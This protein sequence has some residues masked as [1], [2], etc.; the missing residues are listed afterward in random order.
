MKARLAVVAL[1]C[2]G[3]AGC[4]SGGY[5]STAPGS[6]AGEGGGAQVSASAFNGVPAAAA[7]TLTLRA[8]IGIELDGAQAF[9]PVHAPV[10]ATGPFDLAAGKGTEEIDLPEIKRQEPG[11]EHAI[12]LPTLAYLQPRG[13]RLPR[14]KRWLSAS[15]AGSES[16]NRNFP[17]FVGQVEGLNPMLLLGELAW[18]TT[19]SMPLGP[20]RQIVDHVP[21]QRYRVSVDLTEALSHASGPAAAALGQAIQQQLTALGSGGSRTVSIEAW[22]DGAGRVVEMKT[23]VP[24]TGEGSDLVAVS[25]FG[26]KV[27]VRT[28]PASQVIDI[29]ALTPSGEREN[30]G[31][32]DSDGA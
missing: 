8:A 9:G 21:A 13:T 5:S 4:S 25:Y 3:L 32:G 2:A 6:G 7:R 31:G 1:A 22:V 20:G 19:A 15:I 24:G 30:N 27:D 10:Y 12:F 11:T 28:P 16:V 14:G 26:R 23:S 29:S 18:G 17:Q